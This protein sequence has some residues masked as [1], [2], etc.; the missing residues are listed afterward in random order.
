MAVLKKDDHMLDILLQNGANVDLRD[1]EGNTALHL[2]ASIN[3]SILA[4]L[5]IQAGA[6]VNAVCYKK[7]YFIFYIICYIYD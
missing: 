3:D 1:R 4:Q 7:K 6:N 5:L 2:V